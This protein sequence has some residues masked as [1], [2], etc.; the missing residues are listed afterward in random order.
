MND[1]TLIALAVFGALSMFVALLANA[2]LLRRMSRTR[3]RCSDPPPVTILRPMKGRD[4]DLEANLLALLA[5]R[6]PRFQLILG[7]VDADDPALEIARRVRDTHPE[8]DIRVIEGAPP[9]GLNPKVQNLH[10]MVRYAKYDWVLISD[11][12]V[13]PDPDY[14]ATLA[15]DVED[16][17]ADLVHAIVSGQGE[18]TTGATMDNVHVSTT[19]AGSVALCGTLANHATVIGKSMF[20]R[21]SAFDRLGGFAVVKDILAED[22]VIGRLFQKAGLEVVQ[23]PYTVR[24][25]RREGRVREFV[26]RHVRWS[27]MRRRISPVSYVGELLLNPTPWLALLCV[28]G[29][30]VVPLAALLGIGLKTFADGAVL[31]K[32]RGRWQA[33]PLLFIPFKDLLVAV[34]WSIAF[35]QRTVTW[36]GQRYRIGA[37]SRLSP[38]AEG[39]AIAAL[40]PTRVES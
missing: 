38:C 21:M 39:E 26:A 18:T 5:Q 29:E 13:C 10:Q 27:Q 37:M 25:L 4:D 32:M 19:I 11:D 40:D 22:Y 17:G 36:R 9:L 12:D 3:R 1:A 31:A 7:A 28:F 23:S 30:G 6:Y 33:T 24:A 35:V 14:L 20:F 16:H 2:V 8:I 34:I 15:A